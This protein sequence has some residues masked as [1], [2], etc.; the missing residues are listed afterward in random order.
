MPWRGVAAPLRHDREGAHSE[1]FVNEWGTTGESR[2]DYRLA[3]RVLTDPTRPAW[4]AEFGLT[5]PESAGWR[6][7]LQTFERE[8]DPA[9]PEAPAVVPTGRRLRAVGGGGS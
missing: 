3:A 9:A 8:N 7:A 1:E 6:F 5:A 4:R 2:V